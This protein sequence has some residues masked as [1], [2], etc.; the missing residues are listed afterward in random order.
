[1]LSSSIHPQGLNLRCSCSCML[2]LFSS[3]CSRRTLVIPSQSMRSLNSFVRLAWFVLPSFGTAQSTTTRLSLLCTPG[4][5]AP[6]S[7]ASARKAPAVKRHGLSAQLWLRRKRPVAACF[8]YRYLP[9]RQFSVGE[10]RSTTASQQRLLQYYSAF[11][12]FSATKS[13]LVYLLLITMLHPLSDS[14]H[15]WFSSSS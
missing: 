15:R 4:D 14:V 9:A 2:A 12:K 8:D 7:F 13:L 5:K 6:D 10:P 11:R 3:A 1:M